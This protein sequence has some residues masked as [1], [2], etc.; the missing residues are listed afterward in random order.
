MSGRMMKPGRGRAR[1]TPDVRRW[2]AEQARRAAG[3]ADG[4]GRGRRYDWPADREA[5]ITEMMA[6]AAR[7]G[8]AVV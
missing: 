2:Q 8:G 1:I 6:A 4:R 5:I 3:R 7:R